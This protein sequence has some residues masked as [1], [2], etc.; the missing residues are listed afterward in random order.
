MTNR[1]TAI[2]HFTI[3][4]TYPF[5]PHRVFRAFADPKAKAMWFGGDAQG[6]TTEPG[7]FDFQVGGHERLVTRIVDGPTIGF[8]AQY[9]DIVENERIVTTYSMTIDTKRMSV[10]V[11][12]TEFVPEGDG[13][14]LIVTEQGAFLDGLDTNEQREQGTGELLTALAAALEAGAGDG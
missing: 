6:M 7:D 11:A 12:V 2:A 10:S 1:T 14:K 13:T 5:P 3:E 4:R 9:Q 8:D